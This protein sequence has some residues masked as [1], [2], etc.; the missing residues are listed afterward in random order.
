MSSDNVY[1]HILKANCYTISRKIIYE[2]GIFSNT[3][4]ELKIKLSNY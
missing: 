1:D 3:R 4:T 2:Y